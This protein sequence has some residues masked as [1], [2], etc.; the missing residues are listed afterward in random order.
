MSP[1]KRYRCV[2]CAKPIEYVGRLPELFPF[3]SSRCRLVDLGRWF[4]E[5]YAIERDLLPEEVAEQLD[6]HNPEVRP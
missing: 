2:I 3:C 4:Q 5:D 1:Q 6:S